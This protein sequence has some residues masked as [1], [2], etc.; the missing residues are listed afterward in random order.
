MGN[1]RNGKTGDKR[2]YSSKYEL[3]YYSGAFYNMVLSWLE[4]GAK[5]SSKDMADEFLR[6]ANRV[7]QKNLFAY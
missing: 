2:V 5:E 7:M 1:I 6:I 3:Y 4:S